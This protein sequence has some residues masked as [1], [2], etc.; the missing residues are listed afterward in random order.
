[1]AIEQ[2]VDNSWDNALIQFQTTSLKNLG[3]ENEQL[4][5]HLKKLQN[6][7]AKRIRETKG[8]QTNGK[9][10]DVNS[11]DEKKTLAL[12]A[13]VQAT[14]LFFEKL[15]QLLANNDI[16]DTP[17][18]I[19]KMEEIIEACREY[20]AK[21]E[22]ISWKSAP[23]QYKT[24]IIILELLF[25]LF[26]LMIT[27]AVEGV[28]FIHQL[29]FFTDPANIISLCPS[30]P[31]AVGILFGCLLAAFVINSL[32]Q[33]AKN[34]GYANLLDKN[35]AF[36][37]FLISINEFFDNV[38]EYFK[39]NNSEENSSELQETKTSS[40]E[41]STRDAICRDAFFNLRRS[42]FNDVG[43]FTQERQ[44][45]FDIANA[46][47]REAQNNQL[48]LEIRN[49]FSFFSENN[50]QQQQDT[51]DSTEENQRGLSVPQNC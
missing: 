11:D 4:S 44:N 51:A 30:D 7:L 8:T 9:R 1:M 38:S 26:A 29:N 23:E 42:I 41:Y 43:D 15:N 46:I 34:L 36:D 16:E 6:N 24:H 50:S 2:S 18:K 39:S 3:W 48:S 47:H 12:D 10:E 5:T 45:G 40:Q 25:L 20:K 22:E 13:T 49:M 33:M 28:L 31:T 27:S 17:K 35:N 14:K 37:N 21:L 32:F 19:K